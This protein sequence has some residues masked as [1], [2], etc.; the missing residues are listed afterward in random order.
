LAADCVFDVKLRKEEFAF[1]AKQVS[2]VVNGKKKI[3]EKSWLRRGVPLMVQGMRKEDMFQGKKYKNSKLQHVVSLITE[4]LDD[5]HVKLQ[6][7]RKKGILEESDN[8][9]E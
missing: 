7:E 1:Y 5:G 6:L 2:Q 3:I 9:E 8:N 4:I